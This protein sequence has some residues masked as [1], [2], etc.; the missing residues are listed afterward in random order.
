MFKIKRS[1]ANSLEEEINLI[2]N[3]DKSSSVCDLIN[4]LSKKYTVALVDVKGNWAEL[5]S[6]Q[7][8]FHFKFGTKAETLKKLENKLKHSRVLEQVKFTVKDFENDSVAIN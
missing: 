5:D 6:P 1:L 7:D 4:V 2:L 3:K 8:L